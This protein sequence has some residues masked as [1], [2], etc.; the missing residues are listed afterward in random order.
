MKHSCAF[1]SVSDS[2]FF[3]GVVALVN[4]LR[5]VGHDEPIFIVDSGL[6]STQRGMLSDH[7]TLIAAPPGLAS[8]LLAP[9]APLQH[10][11]DVAVLLDAD[12]I[13]TRPLG[14][15]IDAARAGQIVG[16]VET[17]PSHDRFF[18]EW[19]PA[20][21][22]PRLRRRPYFNAGQLF[23]PDSLGQR[24]LPLWMEAQAKVDI[25]STRYGKGRLDEPFYFA[26]QDVLNAVLAAHFEP[27]EIKTVEH[28]LAPHPPF[29]GLQLIDET[30]LVCRYSDGAQPFLLHHIL[31]KPWL[32]ATRTTI[33]SLLLSRLLLAPDVV[34]RLEPGQLPLRL[35]EGRLAAA[36]RARAH[37]QTVIYS[38]ARSQ[39]GRFGIRTRIRSWRRRRRL[40]SA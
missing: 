38:H 15:L 28:R 19:G 25:A 39:L 4:S 26:D 29:P 3:L 24:L 18:P 13:V 37:L 22:L 17:A 32:K 33:Y 31:A 36:D 16:F 5:L 10:P 2:R 23:V 27:E 12:M 40:A 1:Y 8:V 7:S 21:E 14:E 30:R 11:A 34:L 20:L 35:R 6:T 9:L